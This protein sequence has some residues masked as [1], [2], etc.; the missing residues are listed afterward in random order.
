M[1]L[2]YIRYYQPLGILGPTITPN[3]A[4]TLNAGGSG[5]TTVAIT[6]PSGIGLVYL[7]C[8]KLPA[9]STC[10][11]DT[12]NTLNSHV[13]DF[14]SSNS[15]AAT[16]HVTT[17]ANTAANLAPAYTAWATML[18]A[19]VFLPAI[20]KRMWPRRLGLMAGVLIV[21]IS[22]AAFQSCG[23]SPNT[24]GGGVGGGG[25]NGTPVGHYTL[26]VTAYTVSGDTSTANVMLNVN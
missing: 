1:M 2:D 6:S 25:T 5:S 8:T 10:S 20:S 17:T 21:L 22:A 12:G 14:R 18:G 9:K 15:A 19:F 11:I 23:G 7:D 3:N 4:I 26:T 13:V 16:V 24:G